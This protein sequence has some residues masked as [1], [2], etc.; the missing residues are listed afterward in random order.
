MKKIINIIAITGYAGTGKSTVAQM[1]V[2]KLPAAVSLCIDEPFI[3]SPLKFQKEFEEVFNMRLDV[4]DYINALR[5][6]MDSS[7]DALQNYF[8]VISSFLD[9]EV[10]K[11]INKSIN[12]TQKST[13]KFMIVEF[14]AL[15]I[16][17]I[18]DRATYRIMI[19]APAD[20]RNKRL[21]ERES[22]DCRSK[23]HNINSGNIRAEAV[24][25]ILGNAN[26]VDYLIYNNF[27]G[28]LSDKVQFLCDNI[29][30]SKSMMK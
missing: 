20:E 17:S 9:E 21:Y 16:L 19:D 6:A 10:E 8:N 24:K 29:L 28:H 27:D 12:D 25:E 30:K 3:E 22:T 13:I 26:R 14:F 23:Y 15:P 7:S 18:W 5:I 4:N 2:K 1:L 11:I